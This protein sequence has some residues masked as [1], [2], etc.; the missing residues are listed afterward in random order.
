[1]KTKNMIVYKHN[2]V[3]RGHFVKDDNALTV[4]SE[5]DFDVL[6]VVYRITQKRFK[7]ILPDMYNHADI[8]KYSLVDIKNELGLASNKYITMIKE[9]I[10]RIY[11]VSIIMKNF[12]HPDSGEKMVEAHTRIFNFV[13]FDK[14]DDLN[15]IHIKIEPLFLNPILRKKANY[16]AIDLTKSRAIRSKYGKRLYEHLLSLKGYRN[17]FTLRVDDLN[18]LFGVNEN[19]ISY[20]TKILKRIYNQVN[21]ELCFKYEVHKKDKCVS[22]VIS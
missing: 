6:N 8:I 7:N 2:P 13:G 4:L 1:M 9:S 19:G 18:K 15:I 14:E 5:F 16:T 21:D 20:F 10:M 3:I 17:E 11:D 12:I 22:F